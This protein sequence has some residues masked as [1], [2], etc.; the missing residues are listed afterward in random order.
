MKRLI[1]IGLASVLVVALAAPAM[2]MHFE[3]NGQLRVRAWYLDNYWPNERAGAQVGDFE[4]IDQRFRTTLTWGL[5]ESVFLRARADINEGFWGSNVGQVTE[6]ATIDP[7]TGISAQGLEFENIQAKDQIAFDQM[8]GQVAFPGMPLTMTIG[9]QPANWGT[10]AFVGSDNRDRLK[11]I[12]KV[13]DWSLGLVY[14]KFIESFEQELIGAASDSRG[15]GALIAGSAGGWKMGFIYYLA[16][17]EA[18][19][20]A[21]LPA[22]A[23]PSPF[24][25]TTHGFTP[26]IIGQAGPVAIKAELSY[27]TGEA[28]LKGGPSTDVEGLG[29][30]LGGFYQAGMANLGLE[31]GYSQGNDPNTADGEGAVRHDYH[32][33]FNSIILFNGMD[34]QGYDNLANGVGGDIGLANALAVKGTVTATPSEKLSLTGAVVWAQRDEVQ[35][36]GQSD[37]LG[38]EADVIA[39]YNLYDNVAFTAGLGYL[40]VGDHYGVTDDPLGLMVGGQ[41]KF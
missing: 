41:V 9:R 20:D 27:A 17:N 14:D 37:E 13:G 29:A 15:Y 38:F 32:T 16:R 1:A 34:Y 21:F 11:L 5:T 3:M 25:N 39:T 12:Y 31:F 40:W 28:G 24:D 19:S 7:V 23:D 18:A 33:P 35:V 4:F 36:P 30:Y 10:K 6:V 26:Y 2:A 8:Y 22:G